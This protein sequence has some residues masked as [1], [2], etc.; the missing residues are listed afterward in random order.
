M[1]PEPT[2]PKTKWVRPKGGRSRR[3][4]KAKITKL[5]S[6]VEELEAELLVLRTAM[7]FADEN[8]F[9]NR[10]GSRGEIRVPIPRDW[11]ILGEQDMHK[12][13]QLYRVILVE[14]KLRSL[15]DSLE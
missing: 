9:S 4:L 8:I 15:L 2:Q 12:N 1:D 13:G 10:G 5:K 7:R 11:H 6:R 14:R 3:K